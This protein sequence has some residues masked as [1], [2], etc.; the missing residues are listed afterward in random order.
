MSNPDRTKKTR[1][2]SGQVLPQ[3]SILKV[4][5]I[6]NKEFPEPKPPLHFTSSFE[7]MVA[8]ALSAQCTDERVNQVTPSLFPAYN[9]PEKMLVLGFERLRT[10]IHS[11]GYH[12]QKARNLLACC[13]ALIKR[14][15]GKIPQTMEELTALH[16]IGRKSASVILSQAFGVP[17]FPVDTHVF[18]VA[19]RI[20]LVHEP[21]RDKTD[22][23]LRQN[24]PKEHWIP[25]H[26]QL[27]FHGRKTCKAQKPRCGTCP[28][29]K[30]CLYENKNL[31]IRS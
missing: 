3:E 25:F 8:V 29:K 6:L 11:C 23:A 31:K 18:R 28:I 10:L 5:E 30:I 19:N 22:E 26:L 14:H 20:G 13:E 12:N 24:I 21:T 16:G 15:G 2:N 17:T 1:L 7:L 4:V 27:I 9:T